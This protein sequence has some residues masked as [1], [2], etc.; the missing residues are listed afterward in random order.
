MF[1]YYF[2]H[3]DAQET[4]EGDDFKWDSDE[5]VEDEKSTTQAK[6]PSNSAHSGNETS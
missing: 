1:Y 6:A 4:D 2:F 5:E 3:A